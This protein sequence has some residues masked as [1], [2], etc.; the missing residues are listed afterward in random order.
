MPR[1]R[2]NMEMVFWRCTEEW[3]THWLRGCFRSQ[4]GISCAVHL[5]D[6]PFNCLLVGKASV[7]CILLLSRTGKPTFCAAVLEFTLRSKISTCCGLRRKKYHPLGGITV[8]CPILSNHAWV[9]T[10]SVIFVSRKV[11]PLYLGRGGGY[12]I[13]SGCT[14]RVLGDEC[15]M[16]SSTRS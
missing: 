15:C 12:A 10:Q 13:M 3:R 11:E 2:S 1:R 9:V 7:P 8:C 5:R 14:L 16:S 4:E 6:E